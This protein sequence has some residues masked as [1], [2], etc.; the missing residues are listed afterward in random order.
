MVE[1]IVK[2]CVCLCEQSRTSQICGHCHATIQSV[3]PARVTRRHASQDQY[4]RC[5]LVVE[6]QLV[7]G[8]DQLRRKLKQQY[9][10]GTKSCQVSPPDTGYLNRDNTLG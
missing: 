8:M 6:L 9:I 1:F 5:I 10:M 2:G 7:G 4:A 3:L